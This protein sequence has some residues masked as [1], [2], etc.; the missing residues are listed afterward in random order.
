MIYILR[1]EAFPVF[2]VAAY[3]KNEKENLTQKER[4]ELAK[5]AEEI[6]TKYRSNP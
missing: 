1:N 4:N 2:L 5:R 3:A 6:F